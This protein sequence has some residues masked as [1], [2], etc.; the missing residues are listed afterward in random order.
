MSAEHWDWMQ[1]VSLRSAFLCSQAVLPYLQKRGGSIINISSV[2]FL[3]GAVN[4]SAYVSAKGGMIGLT[5][6]LA[7]ELGGKNIRVNAITPGAV[8]TP[9]EKEVV[10]AEVIAEIVGKQCLKRRI[11]PADIANVA[12]FLASDLGDAITGQ[13]INVD[14]GWAFH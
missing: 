2:T 1:K 7:R 4:A 11:K 3:V 13:T 8:L 9:Q 6:S 5:R 14:G 12:L 10:T